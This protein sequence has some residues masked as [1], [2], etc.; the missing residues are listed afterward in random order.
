MPNY[1]SFVEKSNIF[2]FQKKNLLGSMKGSFGHYFLF[3]HYSGASWTLAWRISTPFSRVLKT[4]AAV[5]LDL[6]RALQTAC[7]ATACRD[8]NIAWGRKRAFNDCSGNFLVNSLYWFLSPA[9]FQY[10]LH[11]CGSCSWP[12]FLQSRGATSP[13]SFAFVLAD[14]G[15]PSHRQL[16]T[17][18]GK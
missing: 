11:S 15:F 18:F 6:Q 16:P 10:L 8:A 14:N 9:V 5:T 13:R 7:H 4:P 17:P 3:R 12:F 2:L 1:I